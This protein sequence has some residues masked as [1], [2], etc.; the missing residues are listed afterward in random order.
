MVLRKYYVFN[1]FI[2]LPASSVTLTSWYCATS[3]PSL[4]LASASFITCSVV[5]VPDTGIVS[6]G[7]ATC[8]RRAQT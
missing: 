8:R 1:V 3:S 2:P 4:N 7:F 6:D 5:I